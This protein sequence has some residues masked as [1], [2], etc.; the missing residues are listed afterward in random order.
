[1]NKNQKNQ[2][3]MRSAWF[4]SLGTLLSRI[5]GFVRDA[6]IAAL[7]DRT[8]TDV[9]SAAFALPNFF[10]RF[11]GEGALAVSFIPV[12]VDRLYDPKKEAEERTFRAR[13]LSNAVFTLLSLVSMVVTVVLFVMMRQIIVLW[14]GEDEFLKV[15]GKLDLAVT[16]SR[17]TIFYLYLVTVYA[18]F[19]A[20]AQGLKKFFI[21]ALAPAFFN[22]FFIFIFF[23][24]DSVFVLPERKLAWA[25]I[26]GGLVQLSMVS[27]QLYRLGFLPKF[28]LEL[29]LPGVSEVL[30]NMAPGLLGLGAAQIM[31]IMNQKFAAGLAE[32]AMTHVY[33]MNRLLE[34]PQ[35]LIAISIGT[36]LL[37][38]LSQFRSEGKHE[39]MLKA[40]HENMRMLLFLSFPSALGLFFLSQPIV[41]MLFERGMWTAH[42]TLV[43]SR[44]VEIIALTLLFNGITRVLIPSFY[45]IKNTL[46]PALLSVV[47]VAFHIIL[48]PQLM[49]VMGINGLVWSVTLSGLFNLI[50]TMI[51]YYKMIGTMYIGRLGQYFGQ[52]M[53]G[54]LALAVIVSYGYQWVEGLMHGFLSISLSNS[55]A[56][57]I[58]IAASIFAFFFIGHLLH[59]KEAHAI[60]GRWA[61]RFKKS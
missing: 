22:L 56:L 31:N 46:V 2:S 49:K 55:I 15:P 45:A 30:K 54:L 29:K 8:V 3:V 21:P 35:S 41:K 28:T 36:A 24:P 58:C 40:S 44:L 18:Y 53:P 19:M 6:V 16:L 9:F 26:I 13:R 52:L 42:D 48:A 32:G 20:I 7:F 50:L 10:R 5:L 25:V 60:T 57:F 4:M 61:R 59:L 33:Y 14:L 1:M 43:V 27:V 17:I 23:V 37:P 11:L 12:F 47:T 51:F 34:L 39:E 38:T